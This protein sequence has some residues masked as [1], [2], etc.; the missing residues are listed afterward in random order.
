MTTPHP[1]RQTPTPT[2][3]KCGCGGDLFAVW[4]TDGR[5][6]ALCEEHATEIAASVRSELSAL[7]S[8][9]DCCGAARI[10]TMSAQNPIVLNARQ[11]PRRK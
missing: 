4:E 1:H 10:S 2:S 6:V 3:P 8:V 9:L 5:L 7:L 11:G